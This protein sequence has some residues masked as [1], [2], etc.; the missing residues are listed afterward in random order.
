[1][2]SYLINC[3]KNIKEKSYLELGIYKG[4]TFGTVEAKRKVSVDLHQPAMFQMLTDDYFAQLD[5]NEKFDAIYI[6]ANHNFDFV[7]RDFNNSVEHLNK[8]GIIFVHDLVPPT[9]KDTVPEI[10][11]DGFKLLCWAFDEDIEFY[12]LDGDYG[13]TVFPFL[14][15]K[16][17]DVKKKHF[18]TVVYSGLQM[19]LKKMRLYSVAELQ[20][21][22]MHL[23]NT[24][25]NIEEIKN[26]I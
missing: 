22:V 21:I 26:E 11:E 18:Q 15:R 20:K 3:V 19:R 7:V 23:P 8:D 16:I 14:H 10:C 2:A 25:K 13:L 9:I 6:D 1:M 12:T 24:M 5:P 4:I 17:D